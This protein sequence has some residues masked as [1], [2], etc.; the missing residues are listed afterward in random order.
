MPLRTTRTRL[1]AGLALACALLAAG[2]VAGTVL[3]DHHTREAAPHYGPDEAGNATFEFLDRRD[4]YPG[5]QD[6]E[7][8]YTLKGGEIY[9]DVGASDGVAADRFVVETDAVD[10]SDC[11]TENVAAFG[12]DRGDDGR[13]DQYDQY[14]QDLLEHTKAAYYFDDGIVIEFYEY[15]DFG[16]DPPVVYAEDR[17]VL[18][19]SDE[20]AGGACADTTSEKGWYSAETFLNGTGPGDEENDQEEDR[21]DETYGF[22]VESER[23]YVC[24]CD[25]EAEARETLGPPPATPTETASGTATATATET[26]M[27]TATPTP[28]DRPRTPTPDDTPVATATVNASAGGTNVSANATVDD[29]GASGDASVEAEAAADRPAAGPASPT[30]ADGPGLGP[31]VAVLALAGSWLLAVRRA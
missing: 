19:L 6:V 26:A 24:H 8:R 12:I 25:S 13:D 14:D 7:V 3:A 31:V 20:A 27:P 21:R 16:G 17:I 28:T 4:H 22:T 30:P 18:E 23:N 11:T 1:V 5:A 29:D 15:E 10:H 9:G 2:A